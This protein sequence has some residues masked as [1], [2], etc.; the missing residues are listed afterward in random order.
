MI[1]TIDEVN[2]QNVEEKSPCHR[3]IGKVIRQVAR[4]KMS[5]PYRRLSPR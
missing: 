2:A 4:V 3:K 5:N 1:R